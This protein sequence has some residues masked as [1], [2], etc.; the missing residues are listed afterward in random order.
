MPSRLG[1]FL[2]SELVETYVPTLSQHEVAS[3]VG[4]RAFAALC[5][6][7]GTQLRKLRSGAVT[8]VLK[9]FTKASIASSLPKRQAL[10]SSMLSY[11]IVI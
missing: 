8:D 7:N 9:R 3:R 2:A 6:G 4:H 5:T 11:R 10:S 1:Y